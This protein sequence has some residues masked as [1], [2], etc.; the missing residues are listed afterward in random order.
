MIS[1]KVKVGPAALSHLKKKFKMFD[2]H[3]IQEP[4]CQC[5]EDMN[6]GCHCLSLLWVQFTVCELLKTRVYGQQEV[7]SSCR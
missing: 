1:V 4:Q 6:I 3:T 5:G 7:L 2:V